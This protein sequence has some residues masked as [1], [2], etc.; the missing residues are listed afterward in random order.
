MK[1]VAMEWACVAKRRQWLGKEIYGVWSGGC[2][3]K[4]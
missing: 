4:K 3:A 2:H 1:Q